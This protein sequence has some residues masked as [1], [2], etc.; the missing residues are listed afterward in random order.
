MHPLSYALCPSS[1]K[2]DPTE[3]FLVKKMLCGSA[4]LRRQC[5]IRLPITP[6]ILAKL[7]EF[8]G[9]VVVS[10][11]ER[12]L[13]QAM[14]LL[15][16]YAF[17]RLGEM[18][19]QSKSA[20][21]SS[22]VLQVDNI[23][24]LHTKAGTVK[25]MNVTIVNFKHNSSGR[26]VSILVK[27]SQSQPCPVAHMVKY[28]RLRGG[29]LGPLF[30]FEGSVPVTRSYFSQKLSQ[31]VRLAGFD[32]C[33]FKGHSFRIG[34][35]TFAASKGIPEAKIQTMGRWKSSAFRKYIRIQSLTSYT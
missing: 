21:H 30:V 16:F 22:S 8:T 34:A 33:K 28:L 3:S 32:P 26:P 5:D 29:Q 13:L 24:L 12:V 20:K 18:A 11:Y 27:S 1:T 9:V 6:D 25:A 17:L 23:A 19:A 2:L 15:A 35:A 31:C 14:F 4:N 7:V 10:K